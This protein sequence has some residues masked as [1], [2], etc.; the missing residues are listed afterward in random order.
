[1]IAFEDIPELKTAQTVVES[2]RRKIN[3]GYKA[4]ETT[5]TNCKKLM[6]TAQIEELK[7][8]MSNIPSLGI[9]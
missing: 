3:D 1:M 2:L 9:Y 5:I 6:V 8:A 7:N 4:L